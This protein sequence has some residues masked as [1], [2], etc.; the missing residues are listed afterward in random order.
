V[1]VSVVR[2]GGLAGVVETT[3][4]DSETLAPDDAARLRANVDEAGFFDLP[5]EVP[6]AGRGPG[7][8]DRFHYAVTVDD[9]GR[10]HTVRCAE[11]DLPAA[12][13]ALI[14]WLS[15]VPGRQTGLTPPGGSP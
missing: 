4:A 14:D 2:G 8:A 10:S 13:G 3:T 1:K 9:G 15:S 6:R 11:A 7:G 5:G 12:L